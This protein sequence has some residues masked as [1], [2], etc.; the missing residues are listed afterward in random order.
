MM[1]KTNNTM[2]R[3]GIDDDL[4]RRQEERMQQDKQPGHGNDGQ[5]QKHRAGDR[6]AAERIDDD[7][8]AAQQRQ[9]REDVKQNVRYR[10]AVDQVVDGFHCELDFHRKIFLFACASSNLC[11]HFWMP[12]LTPPKARSFSLL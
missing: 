11:F 6:I 8:Q 10:A 12:G 2:H 4:H 5:H 1:T 9:R 7:E 3:A